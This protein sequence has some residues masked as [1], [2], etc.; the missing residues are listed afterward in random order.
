MNNIQGI[1]Q[2]VI[3]FINIIF[4]PLPTLAKNFFSNSEIQGAI[5]GLILTIFVGFLIKFIVDIF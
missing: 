4:A 2:A 5:T 1:K 3:E